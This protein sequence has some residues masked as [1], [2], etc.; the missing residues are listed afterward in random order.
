MNLNVIQHLG[1]V[2]GFFADEGPFARAHYLKHLEAME[3]TAHHKR[4]TIFG[5]NRVGKSLGW[6]YAIACFLTGKYPAWWKGRV[7]NKAVT[8]WAAGVTATQVRDSLQR[9]LF[10]TRENPGGF[11]AKE[12]IQSTSWGR[13]GCAERVIVKSQYGLSQIEFKTYA[14]E[15]ERFQSATLDFALM[16]EEPKAGIYTEAVTRTATTGGLVLTGF[17]ALKGVTPLIAHLL[18]EFADGEATDA[19]ESGHWYTFIGWDDIPY[20]HLS[21]KDRDDTMRSYLP[22]EIEAR[23]KGI[24]RLGSGKVWPVDEATYV[25]PP[26]DVPIYWPRLNSVDPGY[27]DPTGILNLSYDM[28]ADTIYVTADYRKKLQHR[29]IHIDRIHSTGDWIPCV[30]DPAG[31]NISDGEQVYSAYSKELRNP[32]HK[33]DKKLNGLNGGLSEVYNRMIDGRL[34][35]FSTC[36]LLR[37]ELATYSRDEKGRIMDRMGSGEQE[38][39]YDLCAAL[40]Y[41]VMGIKHAKQRPP[42]YNPQSDAM[43]YPTGEKTVSQLGEGLWV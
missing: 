3:A 17:T 13:D 34:F 28:E 9:Y 24:P 30:I 27:N 4:C 36:N 25:I 40:R 37:Q 20:A 43:R 7:F 38:H 39:H 8:G 21:K 2:A 35:I 31:A 12:D 22:H 6:C 29:A 1:G 14:M 19:E 41:G 15:Q 18:P 11:V 23:T 42:H 10:G 33:A 32:T 5:A 26:F 16:D